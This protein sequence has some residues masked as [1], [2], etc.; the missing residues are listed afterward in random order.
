[1]TSVSSLSVLD[2]GR[3][4]HY[5]LRKT[6][7]GHYFVS[8]SKAFSTLKELVEHYS[9]QAD[10]LCACLGEP[11]KKVSWIVLNVDWDVQC[12]FLCHWW[13]TPLLLQMEAPQTY[14]L[15][16]N[17]VDQW[18]IDRK[19]IKLLRK[20]GAGQFGEVFE[21]L[22]NDTTLVAVKTLKPGMWMSAFVLL[23]KN[24]T[25]KSEFKLQSQIKSLLF[26]QLVQNI[27]SVMK[28]LPPPWQ[29]PWIRRTSWERLRSWRGCVTPNWSSCMPCALCRT[30]ST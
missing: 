6:E 14:G 16:Y 4:K 29:V 28:M 13:C 9:K 5:K 1:M 8:R 11:C 27:H 22:W 20:L 25:K 17:T 19:S 7:N 2:N 12:R 10:G 21:G 26:Y 18:E 3:V 24:H 15:S 23:L 30:P